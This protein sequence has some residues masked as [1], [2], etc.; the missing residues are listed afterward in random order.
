MGAWACGTCHRRT[1]ARRGRLQVAPVRPATP[2]RGPRHG[3]S[4][5]ADAQSQLLGQHL[6]ASART[7]D[8]TS[9]RPGRL[10]SS[11]A[12]LAVGMGR[13]L[14]NRRDSISC[15]RLHPASLQR[16]PSSRRGAPDRRLDAVLGESR[17][18]VDDSDAAAAAHWPWRC[19]IAHP[20]NWQRRHRQSLQGRR[21]VAGCHA[22]QQRATWLHG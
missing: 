2:S 20:P 15:R 18:P 10:A 21:V 9:C 13:T 19:F 22:K 17:T 8:R 11:I 6:E 4:R 3:C 12:R 14:V 1:S 5:L 7:S 16:R